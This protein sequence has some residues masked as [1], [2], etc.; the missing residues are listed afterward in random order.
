[1]GAFLLVR[2]Q[3][4]CG[5]SQAARTRLLEGLHSVLL[6]TN[7]RVTVVFPGAMAASISSHSGV[8]ITAAAGS[9]ESTRFQTTH[10]ARTAE[11]LVAGREQNKSRGCSKPMPG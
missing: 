4:V 2:G 6:A 11:I 1:M 5:A 8:T 9:A 3:T 10:P 7:L